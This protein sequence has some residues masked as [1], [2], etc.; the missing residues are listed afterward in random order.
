MRITGRPPKEFSTE[1]FEKLLS[2]QC[3][4]EEVCYF[5]NTTDKTLSNWCQRTYGMNFSECH[6]KYGARGK[7]SLRRYQFKLAQ[8]NPTMAIFLGKQYLGQTDKIEQS[9]FDASKVNALNESMI[10]DTSPERNIE[11]FESAGTV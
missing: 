8:K 7:I 6:K 10:N 11:D 9:V 1:E 5:F 3:T 4:Q 2:I